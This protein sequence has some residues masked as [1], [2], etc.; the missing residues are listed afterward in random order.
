VIIIRKL[1]YWNFINYPCALQQRKTFFLAKTPSRIVMR[2]AVAVFSVS[3]N[4]DTA[5][6]VAPPT[7]L[8]R[9]LFVAH[10]HDHVVDGPVVCT[11]SF[12]LSLAAL[13]SWLDSDREFLAGIP[14]KWCS[15]LLRW[16]IGRHMMS[17][18]SITEGGGDI[19]EWLSSIFFL[20]TSCN[21][22]NAHSF[23]LAVA[24]NSKI[25]LLS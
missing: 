11:I 20:S 21:S 15:V 12:N 19:Y 1:N 24:N 17:V 7:L 10:D 2:W 23:Q 25:A 22:R 3:F 18:C 5:H 8:L 6:S 4:L 13:F 14:W 16:N 9:P